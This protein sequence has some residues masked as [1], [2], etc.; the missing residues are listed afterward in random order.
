MPRFHGMVGYGETVENPPDSGNYEEVIVEREYFGNVDEFSRRLSSSDKVISD[1]SVGN[2]ISVVA[3]AY[4]YEHFHSM[5]YVT[6]AGVRWIVD[7]VRVQRPRLI[8]RLGGV[9]NGPKATP[10]ETSG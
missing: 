10:T 7:E 1:L 2:V 4:S 8:L 5:K 6:W 9:Y 3:D